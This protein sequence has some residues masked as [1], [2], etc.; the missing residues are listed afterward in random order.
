MTD[1]SLF[2]EYNIELETSEETIFRKFLDL[3]ME[4]NAHTN[5]SAI[6]TPE[7]V[8]E[9]HFIDSLMLGNFTELS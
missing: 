1:F 6:R 7:G 5:L 2:K 9:K 3:F 8:I 4:Y